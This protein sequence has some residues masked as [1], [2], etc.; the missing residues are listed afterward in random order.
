MENNKLDKEILKLSFEDFQ[1][2][3]KHVTTW[4]RINYCQAWYGAIALKNKLYYI[5]QSYNT[6]VAIYSTNTEILYS[7]G[8]FSVTTYQHIRK[9]KI[10]YTPN[11]YNTKEYNLELCNWFK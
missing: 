8:R 2:L 9:Y 11:K 7:I 3:G 4:H 5:I 10:N 1:D 6:I